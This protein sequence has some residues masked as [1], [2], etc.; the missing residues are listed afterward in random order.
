MNLSERTAKA[1]Q[2][3]W[4]FHLNRLESRGPQGADPES[5]RILI[6]LSKMAAQEG[7]ESYLKSIANELEHKRLDG[8]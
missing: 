5:V 7:S 8:G 1:L 2:A 4:E 3:V 6:E